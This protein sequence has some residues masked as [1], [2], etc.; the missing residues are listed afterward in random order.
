MTEP[1]Q[2]PFRLSRLPIGDKLS[3]TPIPGHVY[4]ERQV[5]THHRLFGGSGIPLLGTLFLLVMQGL[6]IPARQVAS[7]QVLCTSAQLSILGL[8]SG[9]DRPPASWRVHVRDNGG[10]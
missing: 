10:H 3:R 5:I 7:C 8:T 2:A 1:K 6:T 9:T 4:L